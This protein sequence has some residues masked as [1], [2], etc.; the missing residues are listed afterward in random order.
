MW[1]TIFNLQQSI[2]IALR[3]TLFF[4]YQKYL[5]TSEALFYFLKI[6]FFFLDIVQK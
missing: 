1:E 5:K 4:L 3:K 2:Q 6:A